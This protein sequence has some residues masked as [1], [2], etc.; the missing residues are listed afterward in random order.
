MMKILLFLIIIGFL[1]ISC[2]SSSSPAPLPEGY[3]ILSKK[4][5]CKVILTDQKEQFFD[6]I[7]SLDMSIQL[8]EDKTDS[9]RKEVLTAYKKMLEADLLSFTANEKIVVNAIMDT[10]MA[11]C[12]QLNKEFNLPPLQLVKTKGEYYGKMVFYTRDNTIIIPKL[13][14]PRSLDEDCSA[15]LATMLHEIFHVYS[16]YNPAKKERLYQRLGFEALPNLQLSP[17]LKKRILYNP[18]GLNLR[19]AITVRDKKGRSFKAVPVI[20]SKYKNWKPQLNTF[21]GYLMFQLFE[22]EENNGKWKI[23]NKNIGHSIDELNGF[24]EQVTSNTDYNIHP[25]ELCADNFVLL[26]LYQQ[27]GAAAWAS[28]SAEGQLLLQDFEKIIKE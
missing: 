7:A 5:A 26:A 15:F 9:P 23:I 11:L 21:F 4:E 13:M 18:D 24:W 16:R 28:L 10:A 1:S 2:S 14:I 17:F 12:F 6:K 22:V 3:T 27:Q 25:D 8:K 19:Y 20:Y